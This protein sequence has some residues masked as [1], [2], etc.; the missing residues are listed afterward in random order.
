VA[1]GAVCVRAQ[2]ADYLVDAGDVVTL[3]PLTAGTA[4]ASTCVEQAARLLDA[5]IPLA[6]TAGAKNSGGQN[7][8]F[9]VRIAIE[10]MCILCSQ[11]LVDVFATELRNSARH[12]HLS[13]FYMI[14]PPMIVN[15][16]EYSLRCKER[17]NKRQSTIGAQQIASGVAA[18]HDRTM[19]F[20]DDGFAMGIAYLLQLL[21][22]TDAFDSLHWF[23]SIYAKIA[24]D[25]VRYTKLLCSTLCVSL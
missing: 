16:V 13:Q 1:A 5:L 20:S 6:T 3:A 4:L 2:A 24:T 21:D 25:I 9:N 11:L 19:A 18:Q 7:N 23:A 15:F 8:F 22:Q 10:F 12:A 17:L 14:I